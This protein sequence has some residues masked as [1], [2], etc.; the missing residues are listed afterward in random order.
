MKAYFATIIDMYACALATN[1]L[2][3]IELMPLSV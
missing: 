3:R 2:Q 1:E